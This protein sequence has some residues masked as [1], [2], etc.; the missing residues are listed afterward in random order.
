M[1]STLKFL[2][3]LAIALLL[4]LAFRALVF[5]IF[6]VGGD[7]LEPEFAAGDRVMVNRW[8]Y[9]LRTGRSDGWFGYGRLC[10]QPV[11]RGD[12]VAY[13][14]PRD[15]THTNILFGRVCA[16]PGDTIRYKGQTD[17]VP[18]LRNCADADYYWLKAIN[19]QNPLDSRYLGYINEQFIIGRAFLVVYSRDLSQPFYAGYRKSR[20][21]LQ[22]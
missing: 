4:M 19:E 14:D 8:S 11:G 20:F 2:L 3:S 13:E 1:R 16:L 10:Q 7:G 5:T 18:S 15:S 6:V 17:L 9:G 22:K 12:I 21:L